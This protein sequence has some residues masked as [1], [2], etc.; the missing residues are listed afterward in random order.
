LSLSLKKHPV[1]LLRE[2]LAA[3]GIVPN[4]RLLHLQNDTRVTV[5]GLVLVRQQPGTASGVI[6]MTLEDET[7]VANIIVWPKIF[8]RYRRVLLES[9]LLAVSG[10]LQKEGIVIHVIA[11][12][13]IDR[14]ADLS[15]LSEMDGSFDRAMARA[16]VQ[17]PGRDHRDAIPEARNFR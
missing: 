8:E 10:K 2:R 15:L 7:C 14:T 9:R 5:S 6:F 3:A 17:Q 12:R 4:V 16:D 11:D 13:L 1:G